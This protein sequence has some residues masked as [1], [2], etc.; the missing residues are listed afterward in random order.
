MELGEEGAE[1]AEGAEGATVELDRAK[2][3]LLSGRSLE[4]EGGRE[5]EFGRFLRGNV[6]SDLPTFDLNLQPKRD[7]L[8]LMPRLHLFD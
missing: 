3:R 1:W 7:Y 4:L 5:G 8:S 2:D 6:I